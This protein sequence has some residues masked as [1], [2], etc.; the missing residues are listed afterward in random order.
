MKL[1]LQSDDYGITPSAADGII[2]AI[3]H[4]VL[5]NTGFFSNMPWAEECAEKI[6][7]YL[8]Q[9]ALGIDVNASTGPSLLGYDKVPDL[10]HPDGNFLTSNENRAADIDAPNHDHVNYEQLKAEFEAQIERFIELIGKK[11]DYLHSHAYGTA[12][13]DRV[14]RELAQKY[15]IPYVADVRKKLYGELGPRSSWY[16]PGGPEAQLK[17][18]PIGYITSNKGCDPQKD[19]LGLIITHCGFADSYLFKLTSYTL[20]RVRDLEAVCSDEVKQWIKDNDI[21][22]ITYK[23]L[24]ASW[25]K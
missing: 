11:P 15:D 22:L 1:L 8:D 25:W 14:R 19:E 5:R 21:E 6:K 24:D 4:G 3:T 20:C 12:T 16:V 7:P 2:Y 17:Q 23:E 10:C 9:I 13:T 18:D